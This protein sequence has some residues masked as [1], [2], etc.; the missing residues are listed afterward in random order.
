MAM[1]RTAALALVLFA[2]TVAQGSAQ[3]ASEQSRPVAGGITI[4]YGWGWSLRPM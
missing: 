2:G 1:T 3:P 4:P